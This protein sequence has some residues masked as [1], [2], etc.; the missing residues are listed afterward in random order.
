MISLLALVHAEAN[1]VLRHG[2]GARDAG[3]AGALAGTSGDALA[4]LQTNPAALAG[5]EGDEWTFA[6][7]GGRVEGEFTRAGIRSDGDVLGGF[8]ELGIAWRAGKATTFGMSLAPIAAAATDWVYADAPGGIGGISYGNALAHSSGFQAL[9]ANA[10][11]AVEINP[12]WSVGASVGAVY[13]RVDFDAPFIFQSNPALAGAKVNLDLETDGWQPSAQLGMLWRP[14]ESFRVG[15]HYRPRIDLELDGTAAVDFSAQLPPLGLGGTPPLANYAAT[16]RNALPDVIGAA[17]AW[18]PT[19]RLSAGLRVDWIGWARA[20]DELEVGLAGGSN[21]AIN[22]AIGANVADRVPVRWKDVWMIAVGGEYRLNDCLTLRG[23]WRWG[24]SP[25]AT[26]WVTPLNGSLLEHALTS[27][28]GWERGNWRVDL[29]YEYQFGPAAKVLA[30]GY[31]AGEYANSKSDFTAHVLG[32]G[33]TR[34]Y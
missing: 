12:A 1:G 24:E 16:T 22:G 7:R 23:G 3:S 18:Q 8:P 6:L 4:A 29:S 17:L 33:V 20:F 31:R 27:G 34:R 21:P 19:D 26:P 25:V 9:R 32:L 11:L 14:S 15:L 10:G 28:L 13:S 30:S 5:L 2:F